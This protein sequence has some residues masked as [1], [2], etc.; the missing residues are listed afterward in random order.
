MSNRFLSEI[1]VSTKLRPITL[2]GFDTK[3][4]PEPTA[5]GRREGGKSMTLEPNE[6]YVLDSGINTAAFTGWAFER[7]SQI[8]N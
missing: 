4:T 1:L 8:Y 5:Y 2:P 7:L 6:N 3:R